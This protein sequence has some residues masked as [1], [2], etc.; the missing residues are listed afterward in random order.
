MILC[1]FDGRAP[2]GGAVCGIA[3]AGADADAVDAGLA[4]CFGRDSDIR[5]GLGLGVPVFGEFEAVGLGDAAYAPFECGGF[6]AGWGCKCA[7]FEMPGVFGGALDFC[8]GGDFGVVGIEGEIAPAVAALVAVVGGVFASWPAIGA[9][10]D[11]VFAKPGKSLVA[12][13]RVQWPPPWS[14][15]SGLTK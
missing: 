1:L 10:I 15:S 2:V 11:E 4:E 5:G 9:K 3:P 6:V 7:G 8:G 14:A 13:V 12:R